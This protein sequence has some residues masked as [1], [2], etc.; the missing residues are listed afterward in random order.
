MNRINNISPFTEW[1]GKFQAEEDYLKYDSYQYNLLLYFIDDA[2]V[3]V[4]MGEFHTRRNIMD[5]NYISG[6]FGGIPEGGCK[7]RGKEVCVSN[8]NRIIS[9]V[10]ARAHIFLMLTTRTVVILDVFP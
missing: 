2:I 5:G 3:L 9:P 4:V 1:N 8:K 10:H 7:I 6:V